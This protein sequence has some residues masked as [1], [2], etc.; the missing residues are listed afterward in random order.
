MLSFWIL[1][2]DM[3]VNHVMPP[4]SGQ[5]LLHEMVICKHSYM[6]F[7]TPLNGPNEMSSNVAIEPLAINNNNYVT[8]N[9]ELVKA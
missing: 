4:G 7:H 6:R 1:G 8:G 3:T 5:A 9:F 2:S